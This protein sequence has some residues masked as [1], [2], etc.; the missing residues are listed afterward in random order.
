MRADIV[1]YKTAVTLA[2]YAGRLEATVDD[3]GA[4]QNWPCPI[5]AGANRSMSKALTVAD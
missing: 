3:G 4:R 5:A 2:A 1:I